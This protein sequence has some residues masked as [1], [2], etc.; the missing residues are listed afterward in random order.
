MMQDV[1]LSRI[2]ALRARARS[3]PPPFNSAARWAGRT[4][5]RLY[6]RSR[7]TLSRLSQEVALPGR[8]QVRTRAQD[9]AKVSEFWAVPPE[10][11]AAVGGMSWMHHPQVVRRLAIKA[12]D[13]TDADPY[14]HLMI[15]L[16][17]EGWSFPVPRVLSLGCGHGALER[18]LVQI[19]LAE[20]CD[21][22]DLS[23]GAITEARRLAAEA[24][25]DGQIH[26]TVGDLEE[27]AFPEGTF[28]I[29][30]FHHSMHHIE[31]LEG[32]CVAVRRALR[33]GGILHL[34]EFV[35]PDR[36]QWTDAQLHHLNGFIQALPSRYRRLV[37]GGVMPAIVRPTVEQMI[38]LDPSE[39]VRS[40]AIM[41]TVG[42]HFR[43]VEVR[44]LGGAL[45]HVGLSG[46][47]QNFDPE[48]PEDAAHIE[49]FFELEDRLMAQ[50]VIGSDFV[51]VAA[52]RD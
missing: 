41:E 36:F 49:A 13:R 39:A 19:G 20:R 2:E 37:S 31:E 29:V 7:K 43:V 50:G 34:D 10:E 3:L 17:E 45:L 47:A 33:P 15:K 46:I 26:Y 38:A 12:S 1:P 40:S 23:E 11:Q 8:G 32:L 30:F 14:I 44:E 22:I 27:A 25:L 42:R 35:G 21:G 51:T 52:V 16:R 18:G 4:A 24:G 9:R 5:Y 48:N 28:D 6:S